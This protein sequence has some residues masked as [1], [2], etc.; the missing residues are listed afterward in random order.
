MQQ[1]TNSGWRH[2]DRCQNWGEKNEEEGHSPPK[3]EEE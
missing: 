2:K 3:N 1:K